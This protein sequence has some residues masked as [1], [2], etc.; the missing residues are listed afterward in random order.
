MATV[1]TP[2][3]ASSMRIGWS[4]VFPKVTL[5][6]QAANVEMDHGPF[7]TLGARMSALGHS[8][9]QMWPQVKAQVGLE[10]HTVRERSN[11]S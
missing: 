2:A 8:R 6:S 7:Q 4:P 3:R 5:L 9:K 10:G 11:G 1:R